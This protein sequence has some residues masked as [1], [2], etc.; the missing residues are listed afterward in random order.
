LECTLCSILP[1]GINPFSPELAVRQRSRDHLVRCIE[2]AAEMG[3]HLLGGPL[4][5]PIGYLPGHRPTDDEWSW[6]VD[7]FQSVGDL[8]KVND[9]TLSIE[10]VNRSETFFLP[11]L[12]T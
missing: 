2:T 11:T 5:A 3:V 6:E 10:P 7:L 1:V 4:F 8:L 12:N 9:I